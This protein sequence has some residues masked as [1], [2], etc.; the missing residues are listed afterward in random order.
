MKNFTLRMKMLVGGVLLV[1]VPMVILGSLT[2][3]RATA[4][5]ENEAFDKSLHIAQRLADMTQA[6][7]E[8]EVKLVRSLT[9][10]GRLIAAL[11]TLSKG[12]KEQATKDLS[13]VV[14]NFVP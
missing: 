10:D 2:Y 12:E 6:V 7:M 4:A 1:L 14:G 13:E 5:V 11:E 9:A 3:L 8:E